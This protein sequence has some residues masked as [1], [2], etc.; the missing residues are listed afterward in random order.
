MTSRSTARPSTPRQALAHYYAGQ[1]PPVITLQ[2]TN[3]TTPENVTVTFNS[4]AYGA[5][6][7][8]YQWYLSDS[9]TQPRPVAG[10]TSQN[11]S[12]VTT[13][14]QSG[15][16]YQLVVTN[17]YGAT[18]GAVAELSVV[19]G[20]P[21]FF[22]DLNSADIFSIGHIIQLHVYVGGTAPFTYQWQ[23]DGVNLVNDYR[24]SGAQSDT[25]TI[26][27]A[28]ATD[29]GN[30]RV[31]VSNGQGTTPSTVDA[32]TVTNTGSSAAT[33]NAAGTGG[34]DPRAPLLPS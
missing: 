26:G 10:Q 20:A 15:N 1:Q 8:S 22:V 31:L 5:G 30:Y 24:T 12:F 32:V 14:A 33:F 28:K 34:A 13:A 6:S 23:K 7:L 27:Y 2:P 21:S 4:A 29:S 17:Q 9:V 18:T 16:F 19:S 11:L 3:Q 25:L